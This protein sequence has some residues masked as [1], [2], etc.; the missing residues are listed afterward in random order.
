MFKVFVTINC[1]ECGNDFSQGRVSA[2]K[3]P[4]D[5]KTEAYELISEASKADWD[6]FQE[7]IRCAA[8][9]CPDSEF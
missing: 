1:D 8:C 7:R 2:S 6:F 9:N 4:M 5:W 3:D